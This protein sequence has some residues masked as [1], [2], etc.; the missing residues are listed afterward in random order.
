MKLELNSVNTSQPLEK[1]TREPSTSVSTTGANTISPASE[2]RTTFH[3]DAKTV[4]SLVSQALAAPEVRQDKI[5]AI[6]Q[7]I[8]NGTYKFDANK[9]AEAIIADSK[10]F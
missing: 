2:D 3:S 6:K 5:D 8:S 10:Q 1:S 7:S 9:V 4:Q